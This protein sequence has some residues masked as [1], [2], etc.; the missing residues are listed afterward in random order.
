[1]YKFRETKQ[2]MFL[3]TNKQMALLIPKK[4]FASAAAM[5]AF[6]HMARVLPV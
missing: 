4:S 2:W 5:D 1:M 6:R 3:Y